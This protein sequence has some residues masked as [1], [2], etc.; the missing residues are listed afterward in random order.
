[1]WAADELSKRI[2]IINKGHIITISEPEEL[3]RAFTR[4]HLIEVGVSGKT[5][6]KELSNTLGCR[7]SQLG[8]KYLVNAEEINDAIH[9]IV[10][11]SRSRRLK[12]TTLNVVQP[13]LEDVFLEVIKGKNHETNK[14]PV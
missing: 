6:V 11:Y 4:L 14:V 9:C 10:N 13:S 2:G 12:I 5:T 7:V 8:D 1:M 3:K